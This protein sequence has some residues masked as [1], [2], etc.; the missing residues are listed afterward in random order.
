M[1]SASC[2]FS[3]TERSLALVIDPVRYVGRGE[4]EKEREALSVVSLLHSFFNHGQPGWR[5]GGGAH[6]QARS[7][8]PGYT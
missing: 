3:A 1:E 5:D 8:E 4:G 6:R 7:E 2:F